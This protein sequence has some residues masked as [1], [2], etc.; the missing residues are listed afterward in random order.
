LPAKSIYQLDEW[1][2]SR[3]KIEAS[4]TP[5]SHRSFGG[6]VKPKSRQ[7]KSRSSRDI[8][9]PFRKHPQKCTAQKPENFFPRSASIK[10]IFI[11]RFNQMRNDH[12]CLILTHQ[13]INEKISSKSIAFHLRFYKFN[14][15]TQIITR[16][17]G[18]VF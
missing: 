15:I 4:H 17:L 13:A 8:F 12:Q 6:E 7:A 11:Y 14:L 1:T 3:P 5:L 2:I 16:Y 18:V 9:E 10:N